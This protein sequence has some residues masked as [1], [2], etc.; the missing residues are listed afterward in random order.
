[1]NKILLIS[2][3]VTDTYSEIE[4]SLVELTLYTNKKKEKE[5]I[6]LVPNIE[7]KYNRY[8]NKELYDSLNEPIYVSKLREK[9]IKMI[10]Y[11]ISK[12]NIVKNFVELRKIV[13]DNNIST[14]Y[15]HFGFERFHAAFIGTL[16][17]IRV[18]WNE[19][20][21]SLSTKF[22]GIK[23]IFYKYF[24]DEFICISKCIHDS[25]ESNN[26]YL[27]YNGINIKDKKDLSL[28]ERNNICKIL[29]VEENKKNVVMVAA[30]RKEKRH[31]LAAKI[32]KKVVNE[33]NNVQ[34]ILLGDGELKKSF[35]EDVL[36][37]ENNK[38]IKI[39]GHVN[40]VEEYYKISD[41][42]M[43]TSLDEPFGYAV[44]EAMS[45][46]IPFISFN[47]GGPTEIIDNGKDGYLIEEHNIDEFAKKIID[48]LNDEEK[49]QY[50]GKNAGE[51]IE[52]KF[53]RNLWIKS[54]YNIL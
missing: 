14:I 27:I 5:I 19:H 52:N 53:N 41:L 42:A 7:N 21:F 9:N 3:F 10:E 28:K 32:I 45:Y 25:I 11:N 6:W 48:I 51:K 47:N 46:S 31:D 12:Y 43:L 50:I 29:G 23:K 49:M 37:I 35:E 1:M 26:K 33:M 30:F 22:S 34:F 36:S 8:K 20:W 44:V 40:N 16:L 2:G 4:K 39:M 54:V 13:K 38:N 15:T 18:L 24:V 17:G